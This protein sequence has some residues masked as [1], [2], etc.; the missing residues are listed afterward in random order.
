M[1]KVDTILKV[2]DQMY[3]DAET[4]LWYEKDYQLLI[5]VLLSAQATD[6]SVNKITPSLFTRFKSLEALKMASVEAIEEEIKSIGL[7]HSKAKNIK[8]TATILVDEHHGVVP[9][10][11]EA[12]E[13]LPGVGRKTANVVASVLFKTPRIAV[14]THVSRVSKRLKL[15]TLKDSPLKIEEKLMRKFPVDR[16]IR[17]HHQMI[18]FGRYHCK[19]QSPSCEGC[20]LK[21][22]CRFPHIKVP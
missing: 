22:E 13:R 15:A 18:L 2:L 1:G 6:I 4:E 7:Y 17:L 20:P 12:L 14:D 8:K 11:L 5:A 16:W 3:P 9:S 21:S 10:S 19:A